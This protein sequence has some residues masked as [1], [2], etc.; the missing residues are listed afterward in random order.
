MMRF[1]TSSLHQ[2]KEDE[3]VRACNTN[4][5]RSMWLL[6]GKPNGKRQLGRSRSVWVHNIKMDLG[7]KMGLCVLD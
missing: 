5:K 3:T 6:V 1:I 4:D 2:V 7:K